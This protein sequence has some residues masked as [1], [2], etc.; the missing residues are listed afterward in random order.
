[1]KIKP[2]SHYGYR[3]NLDINNFVFKIWNSWKL[4]YIKFGAK[5]KS[6]QKWK[7]QNLHDIDNKKLFKPIF[8]K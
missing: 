7:Q 6:K 4:L 5:K 1:M 2:C 3:R 8:C